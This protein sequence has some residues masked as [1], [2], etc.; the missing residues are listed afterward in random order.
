MSVQSEITRISSEVSEQSSLI[1]QIQTVLAGEASDTNAIE[2][3]TPIEKNTT[4]LE[5][6]LAMLRSNNIPDYWRDHLAE[7]AIE[8]RNAMEAAGRNKSAFLWY[9]D[10][11]WN[12]NHKQSPK[13]LKYLYAHTPIN[14]TNFGGDV[15]QDEPTDSTVNDTIEMSYIY[16]W[17]EA[18]RDL[19]N[20][21]SVVGNHDDGSVVNNRFSE[22]TVYSYL[23]APEENN[24]M[25]LGDG[26]YYYIDDK[27]EKTRYIYLD[28]A[29]QTSDD[30]Q[31]QFL[32]DA[33][34]STPEG[35]HIVA[36][37]HIWH[38]AMWT[39]AQGDYIGD[40]SAIAGKI[41]A[42]LYDYNHRASGS[43][44]IN[45]EAVA[46][47][48]SES[49]GKVEFCIGGHAHWDHTS[50]YNDEILVILTET[51]STRE[52]VNITAVA[53]TITENAVNAIVA[54]YN[55]NTV[56]VIRIGRGESR[57][58]EIRSALPAAYTN[59]LPTAEAYDSTAPYNGTGYKAN[60][61][62]STSTGTGDTTRDG[63]YSTGYIPYNGQTTIYLKNVGLKI[64]SIDVNNSVVQGWTADK[65]GRAQAANVTQFGVAG[66]EWK[67]VFDGTTIVQLT[68]PNWFNDG[69]VKY[70]RI[71]C[72]YLG[73]D[74]VITLD[75][76]IE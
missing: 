38:D 20:H 9:T 34:T 64:D 68:I 27:C 14:K 71:C 19:P 66:G 6:I 61:R 16:D 10:A 8:I 41:L 3:A 58:E 57:V 7:K 15:V 23:I 33:L 53:G 43:I 52:R 62:P 4:A 42:V 55:A 40:Y 35:W 50:Y 29:Y 54:D 11:H 69:N 17:R 25:V 1:S 5:E 46:Y 49:G 2:G 63:M 72:D 51:D 36:I 31:A 59:L 21:H 56:S 75:E 74:S 67:P 76:P 39:E 24:D 65:K 47:N 48:F 18:I 60:V 45:A 37:A 30:A 12:L 32:V 13:L 44:T 22:E 70:L 26:I 28:T 73:S